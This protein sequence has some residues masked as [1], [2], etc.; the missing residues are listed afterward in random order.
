M[1]SVKLT[2]EQ[3]SVAAFMRK[4]A[5]Y[6][7]SGSSLAFFLCKKCKA[8]V[9][10]VCCQHFIFQAINMIAFLAFSF[11]MLPAL[12]ARNENSLHFFYPSLMYRNQLEVFS[13][14]VAFDSFSKP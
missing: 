5:F 7:T 11:E 14:K 12:N 10:N 9:T 8:M 4:K 1:Y 6:M 13:S 2:L 3:N